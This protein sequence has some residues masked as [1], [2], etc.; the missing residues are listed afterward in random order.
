MHAWLYHASI[1]SAQYAPEA[2]EARWEHTL[3]RTCI[4]SLMWAPF[5]YVYTYGHKRKS[6]RTSHCVD[7]GP[8]ALSSVHWCALCGG[9]VS[10]TTGLCGAA[11]RTLQPHAPPRAGRPGGAGGCGP[12]V[13]SGAWPMRHAHGP[14]AML[15]AMRA[16]AHTRAA[17]ARTTRTG[18]RA[19]TRYIT[20]QAHIS[21]LT[22]TCHIT[23]PTRTVH[24]DTT[25]PPVR[26]CAARE[27][28]VDAGAR[29]EW[30]CVPGVCLYVCY[31]CL[32]YTASSS[33]PLK[34]RPLTSERRI[35]GGD[36]GST[37][38]ITDGDCALGAP[39][40]EAISRTFSPA[41]PWILI[42]RPPPSRPLEV[43]PTQCRHLSATR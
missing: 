14:C 12:P 27:T 18:T 36:D 1:T 40:T 33:T 6:S 23:Q 32:W 3:G 19:R 15:M 43:P 22:L 8:C 5:L 7:S 17:R 39:G 41:L 35:F 25:R 37:S 9:R 31:T 29:A 21:L 24:T 26:M 16:S 2:L 38:T 20:R 42:L 10:I 11:R 13:R 4:D 28:T 34:R 30:G